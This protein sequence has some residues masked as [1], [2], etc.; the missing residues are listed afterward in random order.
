LPDAIDDYMR[1]ALARDPKDRFSSAREM[2]ENFALLTQE[3][4]A[5]LAGISQPGFMVSSAPGAIVSARGAP[6]LPSGPGSSPSHSRTT[7]AP[8]PSYS[9]IS[10]TG[11]SIDTGAYSGASVTGASVAGSLH[12]RSSAQDASHGGS[13]VSTML[14]EHTAAQEPRRV[15]RAVM[16]GVVGT[17][18][19]LTA[20]VIGSFVRGD[21]TPTAASAPTPPVDPPAA[22][23]VHAP[24][25]PSAAASSLA[26]SSV[27]DLDADGTTPNT[28]SA[29]PGKRPPPAAAKPQPPAGEWDPF[30]S[31]K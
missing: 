5:T 20:G 8:P 7:S 1:V 17:L 3:G 15:R 6:I 21:T 12:T 19:L 2:A 18:L 26:A 10:I 25:E 9:G 27:V 13:L 28:P 29:K 30:K 24:S 31:R 23:T 11:A 14:E 16:I 22:S 4:Y